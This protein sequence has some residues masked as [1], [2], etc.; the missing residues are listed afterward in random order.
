MLKWNFRVKYFEQGSHNL[1]LRYP[2][3][4]NALATEF[5]CEKS[6]L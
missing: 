6:M 5:L 4:F 1:H 3:E 2:E